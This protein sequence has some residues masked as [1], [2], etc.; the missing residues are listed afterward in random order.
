MTAGTGHARTRPRPR[1]I[2]AKRRIAAGHPGGSTE[3]QGAV[4]RLEMVIGLL[5]ALPHGEPPAPH[6]REEALRAAAAGPPGTPRS[7]RA[8]SD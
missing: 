5:V 8:G 1:E 3:W 7:G 6:C 2:R 4:G